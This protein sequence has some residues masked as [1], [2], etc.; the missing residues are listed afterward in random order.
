M[1]VGSVEFFKV[2][3]KTVLTILFFAPLIIAVI[4]GVLLLNKNKQ[5]EALT[6]ENAALTAVADV[7]VAEKA[8]T[9]ED[10]F[11]VF[12]RSGVA[13]DDLMA[14][15][16]QQGKL[17][18][19]TVYNILS[20]AGVSNKDLIGAA[21]NKNGTDA[22][23][24]HATLKSAGLTDEQIAALAELAKKSE[25]SKPISTPGQSTPDSTPS[26]S[27][28][29]NS[30]GQNSSSSSDNS[31]STPPEPA[32]MSK[33]EDLYVEAPTEYV[34]EKKI[35]LTFDDGP[36]QYTMGN[37]Y[38]LKQ[39][40]VK[41]TFF[42]VPNRSPECAQLLKAIVAD[43]HAIGVHSA[44]HEYKKIY[45]SVDA[46]LDDFYEAWD[47]IRDA[48]GVET[49]IFRFPGGSN[50]DFN[51]DTREEI[52][53]EM[54]RRGF[55][56]FDWNVQSNDILSETTWTDMWNSIPRDVKGKYRSIVLFHDT[57]QKANLIIDD[58]IPL[59]KNEGYE[60]DK[61]N[62]DTMPIQF[63]GPFS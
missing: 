52:I 46:F 37:L 10:F 62:N 31:A 24:L 12:E 38:Y 53:A 58:I 29:N 11:N 35:Y 43:G 63:I 48:T 39:R 27:E 32:Y 56:Y 44:T 47:I 60:F 59:L 8:G 4:F 16:F 15:L 21:I 25:Q 22:D 17:D 51:V 61:I 5:N 6:S 33:Y 19:Q 13:Y 36:S 49:Q 23:S 41:A 18:T 57:S 54:T 7:L 55:R 45:A 40:G 2:L 42:V 28:S 34:K 26:D 14:L 30:T 9:A 1:R 20:S 50:N 3:I